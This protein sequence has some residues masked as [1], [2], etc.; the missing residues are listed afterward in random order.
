MATSGELWWPST[1][2]FVSA[3]GENPMAAD[4]AVSRLAA[5]PHESADAHIRMFG[6]AAT[7]SQSVRSVCRQ[8]WS[9]TEV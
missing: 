3:Y 8:R 5:E 1:G 6:R 9:G 4:T 2:R 7:A